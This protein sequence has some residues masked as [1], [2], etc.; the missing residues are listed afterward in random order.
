MT[1]LPHPTLPHPTLASLNGPDSLLQGSG[2][3]ASAG[4]KL[5]DEQER[6]CLARVTFGSP[7]GRASA[8]SGHRQL[9]P[10]GDA[11]AS[12]AAAARR[13]SAN[14]SDS[15]ES[16]SISDDPYCDN[17]PVT[18]PNVPVTGPGLHE[19]TGSPDYFLSNLAAS[20]QTSATAAALAVAESIVC[21]GSLAP[22]SA[23]QPPDTAA[24]SQGTSPA[25]RSFVCE[26]CG[27]RFNQKHHLRHHK[28][29]HTGERPYFCPYCDQT[30][31]QT[32]SRNKH[33]KT[34]HPVAV[35]QAALTA[36][37]THDRLS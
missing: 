34:I 12:T 17:V 10:D 24:C 6:R 15:N 25:P 36:N 26:L 30:F 14:I 22:V 20:V 29:T 2:G 5:E 23:D 13:L 27:R 35:Y 3:L 28:Y 11:I 19:L 18:G 21:V 31:T 9:S 8:T 16:C 7:Q 32:S 37:A 33:I 4:L 1:T